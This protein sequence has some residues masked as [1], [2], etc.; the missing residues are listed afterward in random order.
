[1]KDLSYAISVR[2][3]TMYCI[4][5]T[6]HQATLQVSRRVEL[7]TWDAI[8]LTVFDSYYDIREETTAKFDLL[9][10]RYGVP[11]T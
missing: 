10:L 6:L 3:E 8:D 7:L 4:E 11:E 5:H 9:V 1:M 2:I